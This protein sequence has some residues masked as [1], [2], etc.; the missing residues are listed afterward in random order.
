[1]S[2]REVSDVEEFDVSEEIECDTLDLLQEVLV[3]AVQ[4]EEHA[5]HLEEDLKQVK[6]S[7]RAM[8]EQRIP[9]LMACLRMEKMTW[10]G[11]SIN[12]KDFISGSLPKDQAKKEAAINWLK[13]N[14]GGGLI[15]TEVKVN[16]GRGEEERAAEAAQ[17]LKDLGL[18]PSSNMTVHPSTLQAF[19][20]ERVKNGESIDAETLGLYVGRVAKFSRG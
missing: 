16:F 4:L 2:K 10:N 14:E 20:R 17:R 7:L 15:K 8:K 9:E 5:L 3:E 1:M 19:A 12:I 11:W 6:S 18:E 13:E